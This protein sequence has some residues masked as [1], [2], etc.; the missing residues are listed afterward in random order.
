MTPYG[1]GPHGRKPGATRDAPEVAQFCHDHLDRV[2]Y[3][4]YLQW[5]AH[6]QLEVVGARSQ[7]AGL[8]VGVMVDLAIGVAEGGGATWT[9]RRLYALK[10]A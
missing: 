1:A 7:D 6:A 9:D 4:E 2:E 10:R 5:Q 3:F 8:G